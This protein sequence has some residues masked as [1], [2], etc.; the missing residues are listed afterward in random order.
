MNKTLSIFL[1][2]VIGAFL[3]YQ[4]I[5][6]SIIK[7]LLPM[8]SGWDDLIEI[9]LIIGAVCYGVGWGWI[10]WN[11]TKTFRKIDRNRNL[12]VKQVAWVAG[13][14]IVSLIV[15]PSTLGSVGNFIMY[16]YPVDLLVYLTLAIILIL[17]IGGWKAISFYDRRRSNK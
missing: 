4:P 13:M 15:S 14:A 12:R 8:G 7:F 17:T 16:G 1:G 11:K 3:L 10:R 5:T 2:L 6:R 9:A